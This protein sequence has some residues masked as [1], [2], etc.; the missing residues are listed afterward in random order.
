MSRKSFALGTIAAL[1]AS[2]PLAASAQ[3]L[4]DGPGKDL[5]QGVCTSCH[6]ANLITRSSGY[7]QDQW[8]ILTDTMINLSM[9]PEQ[10]NEIIT[11]LAKNFPPNEKRTPK[12]VPGPVEITFKQWIAP[13]LGQR[14]RDPVEAKDGAV[15][16]AGQF[17]NIIGRIDPKT[18]EIKEYQLP[19]KSLPHT[20]TLDANDTPWFTGNANGTIGKIDPATGKATVYVMPDPKARDPHTMEFDKNGILWFSLQQANMFGRLDPKTEDIKLVT[21]KTAGAKPYGVK[22][23]KD[24]NPWFSCNGAPC[25][26]KVDAKTM[27]MKEFKLPEGSTVRRLDIADD[28]MIWYVNSTLGRL[29]RLNPQTGEVKEWPSPSGKGSHPYAILVVNGIVW[30]N[31]SN[32]RPDALVRF[33]PKSEKFQSWAILSDGVHAGHIRHMRAAKNGDLLIHQSSTN[34]VIRVTV[35]QQQAQAN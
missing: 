19:P 18:G 32:Q 24:G 15:W 33:D 11:Y 27:E 1:C 4:P 9:T 2:V 31:E 29:G 35:K 10:Q 23:D 25:I 6:Q 34:R 30:Y 7:T 5:V 22:I 26:V 8:K 12:L 3:N 14:T 17:G 21:A 13:S 28:G 20:I 16:Y